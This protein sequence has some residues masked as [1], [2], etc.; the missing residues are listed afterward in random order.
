MKGY[1]HRTTQDTDSEGRSQESDKVF[2]IGK[3][4]AEIVRLIVARVAEK[5]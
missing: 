5:I 1:T 4:K 2:Q 3:Q